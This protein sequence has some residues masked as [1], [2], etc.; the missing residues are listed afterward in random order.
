MLFKKLQNSFQKLVNDL[1]SES[2]K[3]SDFMSEEWMT[4][5]KCHHCGKLH[6]EPSRFCSLNCFDAWYNSQE[7]PSMAVNAVIE[8]MNHK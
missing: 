4:H 6:C 3:L 2:D 5:H 7:I 8:L 1:P